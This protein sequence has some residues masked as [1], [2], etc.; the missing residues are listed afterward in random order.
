VTDTSTGQTITAVERTAAVLSAF[1]RSEQQTLGVTEIAQELDI[2][3]AVVHRILNSLRSAG[4]IDVD[5]TTRRYL[6]G[7]TALDIG[8]AFLRHVD[9]RELA[10]PVL[11]ELSDQTEETATL[12]IRSGQHRIYI[13]QVTP[14]REVKMTVALGKAFPLHAGSSSKSLLAYLPQHEIDEYLERADLEPLTD[15]TITDAADLRAELADVRTRGFAASRGERQSGAGSVAAPILDHN[16]Y[17]VASMS[18]CGPVERFQKE[19]EHA[20]TLVTE[21]TMLLSR[22]IGYQPGSQPVGRER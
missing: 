1:A 18:L 3:K 5:S 16:G 7:P 10:R 4:F 21:A 6:L 2:S 13:D 12:S 20:A 8:L 15:L 17:P 19:A 9:V 14:T 11:R 22:Q